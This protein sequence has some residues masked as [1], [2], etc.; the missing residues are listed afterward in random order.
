MGTLERRVA[1]LERIVQLSAV[2]NSTHQLDWLLQVIIDAAADLVGTEAASIL[3]L[4]PNTRELRF[5]ASTGTPRAELAPL[6]VPIEGSIAG[7]IFSENRP[8]VIADVTRDPRWNPTIARTIKFETRSILGVPMR[9]KDKV[10]GVLEAV[11]KIDGAFSANDVRTLSIL[12]AQAAVAIENA[13]LIRALQK[14][15]E[16]LNELD[17]LKTD[18]IAI[19]SHELRTPLA[20]ILGYAEFLREDV[21]GLAR[22]HV[23]VVLRSGMHLR[24]LMENLANLRV[25]DT[26]QAVTQLAPCDLV[27]LVREAAGDIAS[28]LA[29][30]AQHLILDLPPAPVEAVTDR[31]K[32]GV[33]LANVLNNATRFSPPGSPIFV[34]LAERHSEIWIGVAD[35]GPGIPPGEL[36]RIFER[37][38]QVEDHM[39]RRHGG[40][41]VGLAIARSLMHVLGGRIWAE[42]LPGGGSCFTLTV[43]RTHG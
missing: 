13:R 21:T 14:A 18:V 36:E 34:R 7:A 5:E 25:L 38:R 23:D 26:G 15:Y 29:E 43:P 41:G 32:L 27:A 37:F 12:A 20:L 3:L 33:V 24:N 19:A 8:L 40:L 39:T 31:H 16:D 30:K 4:E 11:N 35:S 28:L 2:L 17:R 42:N 22:E 6:V 9:I 1:T 10:V